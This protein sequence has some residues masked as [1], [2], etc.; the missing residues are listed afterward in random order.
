MGKVYTVMEVLVDYQTL[1]SCKRAF[2]NVEE[3]KQQSC[4][5]EQLARVRFEHAWRSAGLPT[6]GNAPI[7]NSHCQQG[8]RSRRIAAEGH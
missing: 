5:S 2:L 1:S 6:S 3:V 4:V 7:L 8:I